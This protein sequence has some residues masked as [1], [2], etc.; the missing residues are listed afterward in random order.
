MAASLDRLLAR[1]IPVNRG[2][3]NHARRGKENQRVELAFVD[4]CFPYIMNRREDR[5]SGGAKK[6]L[7]KEK[8]EIVEQ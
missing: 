3:D 1:H 5:Q 2:H 6:N 4:S 7:R 8:R